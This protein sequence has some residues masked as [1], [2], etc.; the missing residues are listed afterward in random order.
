M[1]LTNTKDQ[2]L[3]RIKA[4]VH[5]DSGIG[6]TT[7]I[8]TLPVERT[9]IAS[10]ERDTIPL[11]HQE[12][13]VLAIEGWEDVKTIY[14]LFMNPE[15]EG[16]EPFLPA[17][18]DKDILVIDSLSKLSELCMQHIITVDRRILIKT[19]TGGKRDTPENVY[20]EQMQIEDW[21]LYRTRMNNLL[22]AFC[23]LPI[24]VIMTALS[25]WSTDKD[26]GATL[27]T[28]NMSGKLAQECAAH[29]TLVLHM[30]S[31]GTGDA[32]TRVWRT[33]NDGRILA[34]DASGV[35]DH[36]EEANWSKLFAKILTG[37]NK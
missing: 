18:K 25:A 27:R 33:F 2:S 17:I 20:E 11:R 8:L 1:K 5:G 34:K 24:H 37:E 10:R 29:F 22:S 26:G 21:Q 30:E 9:V 15:A 14:Q 4:L 31:Q 28:P 6:K 32:E 7:S 23:G 19:R 13:S 3:T 36:Y 12:Y 16:L 35:L